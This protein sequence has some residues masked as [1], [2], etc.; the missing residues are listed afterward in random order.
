MQVIWILSNY[1]KEQCISIKVN[2]AL[3]NIIIVMFLH[4]IQQVLS[5]SQRARP[6]E[7]A[8]PH[9]MVKVVNKS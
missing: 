9:K 6:A 1:L 8:F 2:Q 7:E 3:V 4:I 5:T